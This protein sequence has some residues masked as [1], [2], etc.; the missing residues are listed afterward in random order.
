MGAPWR[1]GRVTE[2]RGKDLQ[3]L[4]LFCLSAFPITKTLHKNLRER[5]ERGEGE[6]REG[7]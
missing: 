4:V 1:E 7:E 3:I 5:R 6:R 2:D